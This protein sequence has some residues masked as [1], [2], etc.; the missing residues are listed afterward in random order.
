MSVLQVPG[1]RLYYETFGSGPPLL[2]I[3][4]AVGTGDIFRPVAAELAAHAAV[5][6]YDR[7]GFSRSELDRSPDAA[8]RLGA[9]ADDV[10]RLADEVAGGPVTILGISSGGVVALEAVTRYPDAVRGAV[11]FEPPVMRLLP[12]SGS[13][14]AFLTEVYD[15]YQSAGPQ[16]ALRTFRER[17]FTDSDRQFL[18]GFHERP[19]GASEQVRANAVHWFEYELRQYPAVE[20]DAHVLAERA[21]RIIPAAGRES[22]GYPCLRAAEALAAAIGRPLSDLPG[23]HLGFVTR[24]EE[25]A[26]ELR[27]LLPG[28]RLA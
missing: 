21:D 27:P 9:D 24:P 28:P 25:F 8:N 20:F 13:L 11:V 16:V 3:S 5:T 18:A 19:T 26:R 23:G 6:I 17:M 12:D 1:A 4:G 14:L 22:T 15:T 10:R 2:M 7:R